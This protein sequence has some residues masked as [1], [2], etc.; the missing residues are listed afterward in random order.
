[1]IWNFGTNFLKDEI[2]QTYSISSQQRS[3]WTLIS[4]VHANKIHK[5]YSC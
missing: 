4:Y 3:I 5:L 1:M 2:E